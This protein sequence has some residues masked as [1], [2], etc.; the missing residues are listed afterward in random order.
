M[1]ITTSSDS[2]LRNKVDHIIIELFELEQNSLTPEKNLYSDV[3]LDS[4]D[5]IDL[6]IAF[7]KEFDIRSKRQSCQSG[8]RVDRWRS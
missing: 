7:Q 6:V 5:T 4:L 8:S 1:T 2:E 3:G